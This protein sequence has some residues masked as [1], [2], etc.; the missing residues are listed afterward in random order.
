[1]ALSAVEICN[2]ALHKLGASRISSLS[3]SSK[4]AIVCNDQYN[5]LRK[6]VLRSHPWNFAK[7]YTSLAKTI[8]T[9][10]WEQWSAEFLLPSDVL[11]VLESDL[12]PDA[13]WEKGYNAD[14]NSVIFCQADS[15]K[16]AYIK[17]ITNT[18]LFDANFDEA[19]ALRIAADISY[20]LV[21]SQT[22]QR[23]M[24]SLY[25]KFIAT[26]MSFD[27][28]EHSDQRVISDEWLDKVRG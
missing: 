18:T 11:R 20:A 1:M 27:A 4:A 13:P 28:Q 14:G 7:T 17:D 19:L 8:N 2:S 3:D 26:A 22:V 25:E 6:E 15:L 23:N 5:R 12:P 10:V 24:F 9:P 16:I 21:Q